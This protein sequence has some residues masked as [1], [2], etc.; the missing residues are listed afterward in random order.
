MSNRDNNK[1]IS[2][3]SMKIGI[4]G[5]TGGMGQGFAIRWCPNHEM[6]S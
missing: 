6:V 2:I 5:G 4:V 1:I 3:R